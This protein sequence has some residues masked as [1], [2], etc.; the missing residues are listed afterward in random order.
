MTNFKFEFSSEQIDEVFDQ[1]APPSKAQEEHLS[2]LGMDPAVTILDWTGNFNLTRTAMVEFLPNNLFEFAE[3]ARGELT[4][5][6]IIQVRNEVGDVVDL[7]AFRSNGQWAVWLGRVPVLGLEQALLPRMS[8]GLPVHRTFL[9]YYRAAR[10]GIFILDKERSR[11]SL[12]CAGPLLAE[13]KEHGEELA[14]DLSYQPTVIY[15]IP[16][17]DGGHK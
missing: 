11:I 3:D 10:S 1:L 16:D 4:S 2:R 8:E 13:D 14:R 15:P 6:L 17:E 12:E 9:E 5:A 7:L